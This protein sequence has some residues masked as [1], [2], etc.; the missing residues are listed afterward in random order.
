VTAGFGIGQAHTAL[1]ISPVGGGP[2]SRLGYPVVVVRPVKLIVN[3]PCIFQ[4]FNYFPNDFNLE[5]RKPNLPDVQ[6]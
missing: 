6:K 4:F 3:N 5:V 1:D 2:D